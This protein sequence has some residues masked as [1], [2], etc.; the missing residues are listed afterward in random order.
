MSA[1]RTRRS[2]CVLLLCALAAGACAS[3]PTARQLDDAVTMRVGDVTVVPVLLNDYAQAPITL[4]DV[5]GDGQGIARASTRGDGVHVSAQAVGTTVFRYASTIDGTPQP[6]RELV[7]TVDDGPT[8]TPTP[9]VSATP[10]PT[11][12]TPP[13]PTPTATPTATVTAISVECEVSADGSLEVGERF[14]ISS[15]HS[16]RSADVEIDYHH[17]DGTIEPAADHQRAHY[18]HPGTYTVTAEWRASDQSGTVVCGVIRVRESAIDFSCGVTAADR[19]GVRE[20]FEMFGSTEP[21]V[22]GLIVTFDHGDGTVRDGTPQTAHYLQPG[23]YTVTASWRTP[24]GAAGSERCAT[25]TVTEGC[26]D[27]TVLRE[28]GFCEPLIVFKCKLSTFGPIGVGDPWSASVS[29]S[30][31]DAAISVTIHHGDGFI[32]FGT[33]TNGVFAADG[34]YT[35]EARWTAGSTSGGTICGQITVVDDGGTPGLS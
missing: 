15:T 5:F 31:S 35:V 33:T 28:N 27:S 22:P 16:P 4:V 21:P 6:E 12:T 14:E 13:G 23:V 2:A 10:T 24:S 1:W 25:I 3:L 29:F 11:P 18:L 30:P 9:T 26:S 17:G 7:V 8:P 19:I 20:R 34:V 32:D